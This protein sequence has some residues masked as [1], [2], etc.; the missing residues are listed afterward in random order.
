V[1]IFDPAPGS[2]RY[3]SGRS[4]NFSGEATARAARGFRCFAVE[5][6]TQR[7]SAHALELA[8]GASAAT[9]NP[10]TAD[11]CPA[12]RSGHAVSRG[13]E[14]RDECPTRGRG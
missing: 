12:K 1:A 8:M 7:G 9:T 3:S 11:R 10:P 6:R 2:S 14:G 5:A 13:R 4:S